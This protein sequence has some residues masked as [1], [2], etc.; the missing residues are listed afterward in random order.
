MKADWKLKDYPRTESFRVPEGYCESLTDRV[1]KNIPKEQTVVM[2][3]GSSVSLRPSLYAAAACIAVI[4]CCSVLFHFSPSESQKEIAMQESIYMEEVM[5]YIM[6]NN[7][8]L[9]E[10]LTDATFSE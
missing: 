5:D 4:F 3:K 7:L 10:Y 2:Q 1:M 9:N 6:M 8:T